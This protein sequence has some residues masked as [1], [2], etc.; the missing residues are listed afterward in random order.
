M[1]FFLEEL[2]RKFIVRP[3]LRALVRNL[4]PD[5]RAGLPDKPDRGVGSEGNPKNYI[6]G[7]GVRVP[8]EIIWTSDFLPTSQQTQWKQ[9]AAIQ[10]AYRLPHGESHSMTKIWLGGEVVWALNNTI[11]RTSTSTHKFQMTIANSGARC[12]ITSP[13]GG[14]NLND[15]EI[16][17][18]FDL[19]MTDWANAGNN[20]TG[21]DPIYK[22]KE[23]NGT[24]RI[25]LTRT[26]AGAYVAESDRVGA[27]LTQT[28]PNITPG[29]LENITRYLALKSY[30]TEPDA[31]VASWTDG[32][33]QTPSYRFK[34][35]AVL[36]GVLLEAFGGTMPLDPEALVGVPNTT[37]LDNV[38]ADIMQVAGYSTSEFDTTEF[39]SVFVVRGYFIDGIQT[40][41]EW[42]TPLLIAFDIVMQ[43]VDGKLVFLRRQ[44]ATVVAVTLE[45]MAAHI[46]GNTIP[47]TVEITN[48]IEV[49]VPNRISV[50]FQ[51]VDNDYQPGVITT[52]LIDGQINHTEVL[53]LNNLVLTPSEAMEIGLRHLHSS[54]T[55]KLGLTV[56]IPPSYTHVAPG[57]I[58]S[59]TD[60]NGNPWRMLLEQRDKGAN[61]ILVCKGI[62]ESAA[63]LVQAVT[64]PTQP[65][66]SFRKPLIS[67]GR[68]VLTVLNLAQRP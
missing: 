27:K 50:K 4:T 54:K 21:S 41:R 3:L 48:Q 16:G 64:V 62:A 39:T 10:W 37:T 13:P 34:N 46:E 20:V 5:T 8:G 12:S 15:F 22:R 68:A 66:T 47:K 59:F 36:H 17:F 29:K 19:D 11:V 43:E 65:A 31:L 52:P 58:L 25:D 45:E 55:T 42:L 35:V 61:D 40:M 53:N 60:K 57:D 63:A 30:G 26:K 44:N 38:I 23:S 33:T 28:F 1:S 24:T 14:P 51:D 67:K 9:H 2:A 49:K 7:Q 32:V 56:Q 6:F 18:G